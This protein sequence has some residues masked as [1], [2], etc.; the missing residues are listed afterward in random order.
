VKKGSIAEEL[1]IK[2]GWL[3]TLVNDTEIKDILDYKYQ[4]FDEYVV[5]T[6][7]DDNG[8]EWDYEIEKEENEDIGLVFE[9]ELMDKARSCANKCIFCFMDQL[10]PDVRETLIFKDDDFR[11]SFMT[12]NYVTFTNCS[13]SDLERI[14]KYHLSPINVSVHATNPAVR[15]MM[16]NNRFAGKILEYIKYLTDNGIYIN[17][18][19]VLCPKINDGKILDQTIKELSAFYPYMQCIAIVPVGIS[20]HRDGLYKLTPF[21]KEIANKAIDQ[22]EKWQEKFM[23]KYGSHIVYIADEVYVLAGRKIP[24]YE[25]YEDFPQL[26]D[27]IG[28]MAKFEHEFDLKFAKLKDKNIKKTI[29]IATGKCAYGFIKKLAKKLENRYKGLSIN[30]YAIRNDYFGEKITVSGLITATDMI[31]QLKNKGLGDYLLIN[32]NCLKS[33]SP[34]F[35]DNLTVKDVEKALKT[36]IKVTNGTGEDFIKKIIM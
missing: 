3:L 31:K 7:E 21:D 33:D 22:V 17:T 18:Q 5:I 10:P 2:K 14:V 27:G 20:K 23:K 9:E 8:E 19:V 25:S 6:I 12:G 1:G 30:V 24:S 26:E 4:M 16:L 11:L 32:Y 34:T 35:L 15:C 28:M 13:Y 36:K 29:S